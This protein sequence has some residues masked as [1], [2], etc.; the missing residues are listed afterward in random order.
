MFIPVGYAQT[1]LHFTMTGDSN[2]QVCTLGFASSAAAT[3]ATAIDLANDICATW[4]A[5]MAPITSD[6]VTLQRVEVLIKTTGDL[7][8]AGT[9]TAAAKAGES[10]LDVLPGGVSAVVRKNTG[11]AGRAYRG[12]MFHPG[13]ISDNDVSN[14]SIITSGRQ[15]EINAALEDW[16]NSLA[17]TLDEAVLL[18]TNPALTPTPIASLTV[19]RRVGFLGRRRDR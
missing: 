6:E 9:S 18:H 10:T 3:S 14:G 8:V 11:L 4:D 13:L 12:R 7:L 16:L 17:G 19:S 1:A 2:E 15:I 5:D